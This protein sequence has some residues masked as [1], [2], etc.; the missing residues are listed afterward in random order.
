[1]L[2]LD[3]HLVTGN[4]YLLAIA[5]LCVLE[6]CGSGLGGCC[7]VGHGQSLKAL[8]SIRTIISQLNGSTL[9]DCNCA[10]GERR[11]GEKGTNTGI[12]QIKE[13]KK[14]FKCV[15]IIWKYGHIWFWYFFGTPPHEETFKWNLCQDLWHKLQR[16]NMV[17]IGGSPPQTHGAKCH[18][19]YCPLLVW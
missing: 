12:H 2:T 18:L 15:L 6:Y 9:C 10:F 19:L 16:S 1:M 5:G 8:D 17:L 3:H 7:W 11:R 14:T 4:Q 13:K